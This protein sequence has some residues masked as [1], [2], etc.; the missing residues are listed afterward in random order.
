MARS[1]DGPDP[2]AAPRTGSFQPAPEP[3]GPA[4]ATSSGDEGRTLRTLVAVG[5]AALL[6]GGTVYVSS[7]LAG[8]PGVTEVLIVGLIA[9]VIAFAAMIPMR[10]GLYVVP[11]VT[12]IYAGYT[13]YNIFFNP[14]SVFQL[15]PGEAYGY[16]ISSLG[17]GAIIGFVAQGLYSAIM[18]I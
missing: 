16:A 6:A 12:F 13:A 5:A 11:G 15:V 7:I 4:P 2:D 8:I 3:S 9:F 1:G 10:W 18:R 17:V 14:D